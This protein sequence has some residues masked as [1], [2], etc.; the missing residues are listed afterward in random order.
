MLFFQVVLLAGYAYAHLL[1]SKVTAGRALWIHRVALILTLAALPIIPSSWWKPADGSL[2]LLRILGL[3]TITVGGPYCA[4][5]ATSP[6]L[7]TWYIRARG[8][9]VP[10]RFFALSNLGSMLA[11]LSYP[12]LVEP[13]IPLKT[14]AWIWSAAYLVFAALCFV[15]SVTS[16]IGAA[17]ERVDADEAP[18]TVRTR[19]FWLLLSGSASALLLAVTNHITQNIAAIPFL[20]ILP[21]ALYLLSFILCFDSPRWYVRKLFL[22]LF[23]VAMGSM[24]YG[25]AGAIVI[26]RAR[27]LIPIFCVGLF[28]ACMVLHGELARRKPGPRYL[29]SFYLTIALGGA[30]GGLFVAAFAPI[31]FPALI[32]FPILL[33]ATP[34]IVL[35]AVLDSRPRYARTTREELARSQF[36]AVWAMGMVAVALVAFYV[37]QQEFRFLTTAR[38]LARNFYGAL[39]VSD[40]EAAGVR[41]LGHGTIN[42]GEQFL[43]PVRR[44]TPITYYAAATGIGRLM[45]DLESRGPVRLGVVGLGAGTMAAWG[46][47]GDTVRF[48]EINPLVLS[49]ARTQFTYLKD[50][51]A[52]LDVVLGDARLSLER[53]P[54]NHFDVLAVDAFS[55]DSIPVHLLTREALRTYWRHLGPD[56]VLAIHVS[57]KYLDLSAPLALLATEFHQ[58]AHLIEND[59]S[60]STRTFDADWVLI[61]SRATARFPWMNTE[62]SE[63]DTIPGLRPWSDD[64]SNLWQIL[65]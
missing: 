47:A 30:L 1:A 28:V 6:L 34:I 18:I 58:E 9:G 25:S 11:L 48:Y 59:H 8:R 17:A 36:W 15:L 16:P 7:Q 23:A 33:I 61:A 45:T 4:L 60:S 24:A 44:R 19:V 57:N 12:V 51:P 49:I 54:S 41:E 46:R 42:H 55:G 21:L 5:A 62:D 39:R 2:P 64:F 50:C 32:E 53:E 43:D 31:V 63:I 20:W 56:G 52:N 26:D 3:L 10:Y 14:Q 65:N 22:G 29:T 40:N 38:L 37:G 27:V 13:Y 35:L